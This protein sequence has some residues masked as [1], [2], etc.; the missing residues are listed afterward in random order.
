MAFCGANEEA[1]L[2]LAAVAP[3][4]EPAREIGR[5]K[6]LPA[7]VEDDAHAVG[8]KLRQLPAAVWE[9]RNLSRPADALQVTF[10]K[11]G[12]GGPPDFAT[13]NDVE[14]HLPRGRQ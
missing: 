12:F 7:L 14:E 9:L 3:L 2:T 6:R 4:I 5:T 11:L 10:D 8:G 13:R 1:H